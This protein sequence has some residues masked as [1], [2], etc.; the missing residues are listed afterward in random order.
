M[1]IIFKQHV[2]QR[3]DGDGDGDGNGDG[4]GIAVGSKEL[5]CT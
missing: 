4:Y 3:A 1:H 5:P 2:M